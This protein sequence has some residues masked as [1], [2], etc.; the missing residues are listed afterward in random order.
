MAENDHQ[1]EEE[2]SHVTSFRFPPKSLLFSTL[3]DSNKPIAARMRSIFY[4]RS[5]GGEDS[6]SALCASLCDRTGSTLFRH[7][8]AY[9]LGQMRAI[10]A[11]S[12]LSS[13]LTDVTDDTIVRHEAAE[14]LGA[15]ADPNSLSLLDELSSDSRPEVAE[16]CQV[17]ARRV[18]WVLEK[19]EVNHKKEETSEEKEINNDDER[20]DENPFESIDPA[21]AKRKP[22]NTEVP[23]IQKVLVDQ[24]V[25]LFERY[26][27]MFSLRNC[28]SR[29]A[30]LA[31]CTG[32]KDPSPL[33]RHEVAYVLGQLAHAIATDALMARVAD[34]DEHEMVR[35]EAAEALGA[36]GTPVATE[37]LEKYATA[38][39][40]EDKSIEAKAQMLRESVAVA[41]DAADYFSSEGVDIVT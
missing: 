12:S 36:I 24:S 18:R 17:A 1:E 6:I 38:G 26:K 37:F 41:I 16:T 23:A 34:N 35:H 14:A 7:E 3:A 27:A 33:F 32:L 31:L 13:I 39:I 19:A 30:V 40:G 4:L 21:P 2:D 11:I 20:L 8:I 15:I 28:G 29:G 22:L 5:L 10:S 25:P 9:V